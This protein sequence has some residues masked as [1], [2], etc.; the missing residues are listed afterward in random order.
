MSTTYAPK[1]A[2]AQKTEISKSATVHDFS[3]QNKVLQHKSEMINKTIQCAKNRPNFSYKNKK[4]YRHAVD[5]Y[6]KK[7][8]PL[9]MIDLCHRVSWHEISLLRGIPWRR[10]KDKIKALTIP[11][12]DYGCMRKIIKIITV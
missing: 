7:I 10:V 2:P 11:S 3:K 5:K 6:H 1:Q 4:A 9:Q 8:D 12:R